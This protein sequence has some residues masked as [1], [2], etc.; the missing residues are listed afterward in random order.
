MKQVCPVEKN[1]I[2]TMEITGI[3][4]NGEGVGRIDGYTLFVDGAMTGDHIEVKVIKAKKNYGFGRLVTILKPSIERVEPRCPIAKQCGGCSLMHMDYKAQ[5]QYKRGHILDALER[6]GEQDRQMLEEK[7]ETIIG[8]DEP[9]FYRNKVQFPVQVV[10]GKLLIGF[11]A[12]RSH[13]IIETPICYIQDRYNEQIIDV[14]RN[15][16]TKRDISVYDENKHKGLLR[17]IVIRKSHHREE[18]HVTL[19]INGQSFPHQQELIDTL[20]QLDRVVGISLNINQEK[21]NAILGSKVLHLYGQEYLRDQIGEIEYQI[22]PLSFYQVNPIQTEK[23][24]A[25]ALEYAMLTGEEIVYDLYCGIGT[26]SLFLAQQAK[27][28]YGVEIVEAAI[29]DAKANA[30]IN[31]I[32]NTSFYA[33]KAE[34]IAPKLYQEEGITADVVVVDPPRKGCDTSLLDTIIEMNPQRIVY[35][36]CDPATL[37]RDVKILNQSGYAIDKW[38]GVDMFSHSTHVECVLSMIRMGI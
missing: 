35:V 16:I 12:K 9:W 20:T 21:T 2:Y 33:G 14:L 11:Y 36:S 23:L 8:M 38:C 1:R 22:S 6:I 27:H 7:E 37:A 3:G 13:R 25:K 18:F 32:T 10:S 34:D 24:Y 31:R 5:L 29:K 26:I 19:V 17:H 30:D 15:F 28:V 4:A